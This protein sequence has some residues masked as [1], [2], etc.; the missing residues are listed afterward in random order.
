[1]SPCEVLPVQP[2]VSFPSGFQQLL[3]EFSVT[4]NGFLPEGLPLQR[5]PDPYYE[6]WE[7][8]IQDLPVLIENGTLREK[9][10]QL[11]VLST[12]F[13]H[14]EPEQRRAYVVLCFLVNGYV[15]GG[16]TA[17]QVTYPRLFFFF[18]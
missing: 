16:N 14:T 13:L 3:N 9:V 11:P 12:S 7:T 15:W 6:P 4:Q 1:M 2:A 10:D 8:L 5:L 18:F 17:S